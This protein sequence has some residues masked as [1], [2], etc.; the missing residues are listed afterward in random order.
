MLQIITSVVMPEP[1]V[2]MKVIIL[3]VYIIHILIII[4]ENITLL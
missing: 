1:R 3:Y 4:P 2:I